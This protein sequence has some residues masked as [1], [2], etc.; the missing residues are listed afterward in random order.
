MMAPFCTDLAISYLFS[1]VV[2]RCSL[3]DWRNAKLLHPDSGTIKALCFII[4]FWV[5]ALMG[6]GLFAQQSD[7]FFALYY[8]GGRL[9]LG[10]LFLSLLLLF[11][12][13]TWAGVRCVD[14]TLIAWQSGRSGF[15]VK[16]GFEM[17]KG[18]VWAYSFWI[19]ALALGMELM[20]ILIDNASHALGAGENI[21]RLNVLST[22]LFTSIEDVLTCSFAVQFF[23]RLGLDE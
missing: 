13:W 17:M 19:G 20:I 21:V 5:P 6:A 10:V 18:H 1:L 3:T 7:F 23:R 16:H 2:I 22:T 11:V 15:R 8:E 4:V 9:L 14:M 12:L